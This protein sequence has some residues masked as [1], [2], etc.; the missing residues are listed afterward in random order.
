MSMTRLL[1]SLL[2]K[3]NCTCKYIENKNFCLHRKSAAPGILWNRKHALYV[4]IETS[5]LRSRV[6]V[7]KKKYIRS[8]VIALF[9]TWQ[10]KS[11]WAIQTLLTYSVDVKMRLYFDLRGRVTVHVN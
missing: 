2:K 5:D 7:W 6:F 1:V 11:F 10:N 8:E 3:Q 4:T 9:L